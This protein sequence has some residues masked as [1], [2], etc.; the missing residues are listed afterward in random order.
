MSELALVP[1]PFRDTVVQDAWQEPVDLTD[2]HAAAFEACK[3]GIEAAKRGSAGSLL[4]YGAAGSGKTHL[5]ARL[6]RHLMNDARNAPDRALSCVFCFVRLQT[7]PQ[8]LW[9]HV[10]RRLVNDLMRREEGLTQLQRLIAHQLGI[11][12]GRSA[13]AGILELRV[14]RAADKDALSLHLDEV[15]RKLDL[16]RNLCV[17]LEHLVFNESVRDTTAWLAGDGLPEERMAELGLG[18]D[19]EED[20]EDAARHVVTALCRLAGETLP[21]VF[22]FDQ[23]E[24]LQ[25]TAT[26]E[27]ALFRFA[28]MAADLRDSDGNVF[29]ITCLQTAYLDQ[30]QRSVR[31]AD[32][33]RIA[34]RSVVLEP[35]TS[36]QVERLLRSRL[37]VVPELQSLRSQH[38][39]EPLYPLN[40][41]VLQELIL[42]QP[43]VPRR[44]LAL[45]ARAFDEVQHG[46][47][48]APPTTPEF[49]GVE[50]AERQ[51]EAAALLEP[52]ETERIVVRG[53]E[54]IA[55]LEGATLSDDEPGKANFVIAGE[56][57]AAVFVRN[58]IDGRKLTPKLKALTSQVPR[59]DGAKTVIVRDARLPFPKAAV[60]AREHLA[61]LQASGVSLLEPS[62]EALAALDALASI[63]GD[64]KSGDL[65]NQEKPLEAGAVISW[66]KGLRED[67]A[68]E[69]I[70]ELID[71]IFDEAKRVDGDLHQDLVDLLSHEHVIPLQMAAQIL[72]RAAA[73][74]LDA[75]RKANGHCLVLEGPPA[76]L[77]DVSGVPQEAEVSS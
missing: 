46:R 10:R 52:S 31:D 50:F 15:A 66:L 37:E 62:V 4:I 23:V 24:S 25:R 41:R 67:L 63:L 72:G 38:A 60:K 8:L 11:A 45:A 2:I 70:E 53:A 20:R 75:A 47:R 54:I 30:F 16:P 5:L 35:L 22:C 73:Q 68:L 21:I 49:L 74:V 32:R 14:L 76:V 13:R 61:T 40:A 9:Q 56:R 39:S 1:N 64:A 3:S 57:R 71:A 44:V 19:A 26:D 65:A 59:K 12:A 55:N 34:Q 28:R 43:C 7:S 58:E 17:V 51:K 48:S 69:P 18:V 77:L 27:E 6:Q 29:I 36:S 42:E 33:D